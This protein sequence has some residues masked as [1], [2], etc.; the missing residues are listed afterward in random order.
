MS[1]PGRRHAEDGEGREG[2]GAHRAHRGL[3]GAVPHGLPRADGDGRDGSAPLPPGCRD[4][5]RGGEEHADEAGCGGRRIARAGGVPGGA[6]RGRVRGGRPH[7]G[8]QEPGRRDPAV[9]H[10]DNQGR[11]H[12]GPDPLR[13][14]GPGPGHHAAPRGAAGPVGR[15]EAYREKLPA[16]SAPEAA[17]EESAPEPEP[18]APEPEAAPE[19]EEQ[20]SNESEPEADASGE[21]EGKE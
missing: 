2:Q 17:A 10:H 1:G 13:G 14:A 18:A 9:P 3:P 7:R 15:V 8:G 4:Q 20:P 6:H 19:A 16:A 11:V 12:G 5:V 21:G